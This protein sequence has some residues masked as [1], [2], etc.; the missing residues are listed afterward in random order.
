VDSFESVVAQILE[1]KGYWIRR[2]FKVNLTKEE[3][4]AISRPSSPR[5]EI[6]ILAYKASE[7]EVLVVEC[8]SYLDSPGVSAIAF[9]EQH[10]ASKSNLKLFVEP[11][12]RE[13]VL[14]RLSKQ[15]IG[16]GLCADE[17]MIRLG[18]AAG[19]ITTEVDR[20]KV[21]SIF[22]LKGWELFDENWMISEL[23]ALANDGYEDLVPSVVAKLLLRGQV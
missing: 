13:V 17:P 14:A 4:R 16:A 23:R 19:H 1:R 18:L 7:N 3:K 8:K 12:L 11:T 6:D 2:C 20:T 5:W 15:L 10:G 9:E 21:R 22:A